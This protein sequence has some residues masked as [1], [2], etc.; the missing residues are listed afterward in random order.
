MPYSFHKGKEKVNGAL[1]HFIFIFNI[2][3]KPFRS[4]L[5]EEHHSDDHDMIY[6]TIWLVF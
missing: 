1:L 3:S 2:T 4:G 5:N 6:R